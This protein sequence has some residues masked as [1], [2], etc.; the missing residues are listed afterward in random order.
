MAAMMSIQAS[1]AKMATIIQ[2]NVFLIRSIESVD[3]ER[4]NW[5]HDSNL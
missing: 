4:L 1:A 2:R 3:V 5:E